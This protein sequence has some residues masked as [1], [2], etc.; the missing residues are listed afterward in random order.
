MALAKF[1]NRD[2]RRLVDSDG[3]AKQPYGDEAL[4]SKEPVGSIDGKAREPGMNGPTHG[5]MVLQMATGLQ[6]L[7]FPSSSLRQKRSVMH[8]IRKR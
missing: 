2:C 1:R 7:A 6:L 4:A 8:E 3:M 5:K